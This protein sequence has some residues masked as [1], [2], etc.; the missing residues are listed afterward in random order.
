M[1]IELTHPT[2][3]AGADRESLRPESV[4][5]VLGIIR[6]PCDRYIPAKLAP[7]A[8]LEPATLRLT[9]GTRSVSRPLLRLAGRR[10]IELHLSQNPS[11]FT[12]ALCRRLLAFA[13]LWCGQRA[14]KGQGWLR[15]HPGAGLGAL[16]R[17]L[18][19][20]VAGS[21]AEVVF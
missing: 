10:R 3:Q 1:Q 2:G 4:T 13:A 19:D 20:E 14:R 15:D 6:H 5:Y 21:G 12:F 11:I 9:G 8:G 7:Q 17:C 16:R 18:V